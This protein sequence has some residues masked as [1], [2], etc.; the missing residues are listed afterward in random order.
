MLGDNSAAALCMHQNCISK[1]DIMVFY[2][3]V[4][5]ICVKMTQALRAF[6]VT[7][8]LPL[9]IIFASRY[10][11]KSTIQLLFALTCTT[12]VYDKKQ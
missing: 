5:V 4:Q 9:L 2:N 1:H 8:N 12:F 3:A 11:F 7:R 6:Y 10:L